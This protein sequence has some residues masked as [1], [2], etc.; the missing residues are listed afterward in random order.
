MLPVRFE[1]ML[2]LAVRADAQPQVERARAAWR[3]R[4]RH[5][6][7]E[8]A[9]RQLLPFAL[10][11]IRVVPKDQRTFQTSPPWRKADTNRVVAGVATANSG[12]M[13]GMTKTDAVRLEI[14][15]VLFV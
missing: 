3:D 1:Q 7:K 14:A 10:I 4:R 9:R 11:P 13:A 2:P 15:D 8:P 5:E 6:V 12:P